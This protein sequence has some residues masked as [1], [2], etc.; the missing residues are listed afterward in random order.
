M[1]DRQEGVFEMGEFGYKIYK[2]CDFDM[3]IT[4]I[5]RERIMLGMFTMVYFGFKKYDDI[6]H[7]P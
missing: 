7:N 5:D 3:A 4:L 6:A 1:F 2:E